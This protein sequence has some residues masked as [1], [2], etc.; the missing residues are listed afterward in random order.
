MSL[1]YSQGK[2]FHIDLAKGEV[3]RYAILPETPGRV[4]KDR[5]VFGESPED[6]PEPGVRHLRGRT[7]GGEGGRYLHR[8]SAGLRHPSPWRS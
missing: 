7:D 3:G 5:T 8:A 1:V 2:E 6:C 4:R